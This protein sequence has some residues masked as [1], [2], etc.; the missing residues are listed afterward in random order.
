[1][2]Q[3]VN[4]VEGGGVTLQG[5]WGHYYPLCSQNAANY[6][7]FLISGLECASCLMWI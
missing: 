7:Q 1:M 4:M 2:F 5:L 6:S 3:E